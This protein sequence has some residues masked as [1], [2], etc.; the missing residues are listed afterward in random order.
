[1]FKKI[2]KWIAV[3]LLAITFGTR[4]DD[5]FAIAIA[6]SK[7]HSASNRWRAVA[8]PKTF[9]SPCQRRP[10]F[11]P[12]LKQ[13]R[14]IGNGIS[15]RPLPLRPVCGKQRCIQ[16]QKQRTA[17]LGFQHRS[18][19]LEYGIGPFWCLRS[20]DLFIKNWRFGL[21]AFLPMD[22]LYS[23]SAKSTCDRGQRK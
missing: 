23:D 21:S 19:F 7:Q 17:N 20:G 1:M 6:Q 3:A 2:S 14:F 10:P 22:R 13:I 9:D 8:A 5:F 4:P 12:L 18:A 15:F 16:K 11:G